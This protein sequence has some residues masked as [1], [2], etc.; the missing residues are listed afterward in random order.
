MSL[1]CYYCAHCDHDC[2][3][4]LGLDEDRSRF[5]NVLFY[6]FERNEQPLGP[7]PDEVSSKGGTRSATII[8]GLAG[9]TAKVKPSAR[10][11]TYVLLM[12]L[13]WHAVPSLPQILSGAR[14]FTVRKPPKW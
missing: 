7:F 11:P 1:G 2:A 13:Y 9:V 8:E 12:I 3:F 6:N 4:V 14:L 5:S 10:P